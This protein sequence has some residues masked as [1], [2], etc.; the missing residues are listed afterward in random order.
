MRKMNQSNAKNRKVREFMQEKALNLQKKVVQHN[1][2]N[3]LFDD[4][5]G[6]EN[7]AL[8]ADAVDERHEKQIERMIN[9]DLKRVR[10]GSSLYQ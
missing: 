6:L 2:G 9:E 7:E 10:K 1:L 4:M 5:K 8:A 3:L